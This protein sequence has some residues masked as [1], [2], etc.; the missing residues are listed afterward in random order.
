M[1]TL[2]F[3]ILFAGSL[4]TIPSRWKQ[5]AIAVGSTAAVPLTSTHPT[6]VPLGGDA[7]IF[8]AASTE[9]ASVLREEIAAI[10]PRPPSWSPT[11]SFVID[12]KAPRL[13]TAGNVVDAHSGNIL[14]FNGT[15]YLYGD[16]YKATDACSKAHGTAVYTS[17]DM[18]AWTFRSE[19][20]WQGTG[21]P[22]GI[23]YTPVVFYDAARSRFVGWVSY[24]ELMPDGKHP[25]KPGCWIVGES[26]DGITFSYIVQI[27]D[28]VGINM[29][30]ILIDDVDGSDSS[31]GAKGY[32]AYRRPAK[33]RIYIGELVSNYTAIA[34]YSITAFDPMQTAITEQDTEGLAL[35]K[36]G[37]R[38]YL[39]MGSCCCQCT[40]GSSLIVYEA[41]HPRGP[42]IRQGDVNPVSNSSQYMWCQLR[43]H[44]AAE[45]GA[46]RCNHTI[47]GQL[48]SIGQL[49]RQHSSSSGSGGGVG[50]VV[51]AMLD[52]WMT[53]P[54]A[55]PL[56]NA[57]NCDASS[58][59]RNSPEYVHGDDAQYWVPLQFDNNGHVVRLQQFQNKITVPLT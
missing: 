59:A 46:A 34:N 55:N 48:N 53:A 17:T 29:N 56:Q 12:N 30:A 27:C 18:E 39:L 8:V 33:N 1:A 31:G 10:A 24:F 2:F 21:F 44:S 15:F 23:Y 20:I 5:R 19:M 4:G 41:A 28:D 51:L 7:R 50:V 9:A 14:H 22:T 26:H 32:I 45:T 16:H 11:D 37:G 42:W 47:H 25:P 38:Y 6:T 40:W 13:D 58:R 43:C 35:F 3:H 49:Y 36:R 54:G 52:R 57:S